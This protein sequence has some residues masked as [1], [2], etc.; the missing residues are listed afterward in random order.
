MGL[1]AGSNRRRLPRRRAAAGLPDVHR[2]PERGRARRRLDGRHRE[3]GLRARA[4]GGRARVHDR[5]WPDR[6]RR[7][8]L[9]PP[10]AG[11]RLHRAGAD[12]QAL[13]RL[14]AA[15]ERG[16][17]G[18]LRADDRGHLDDRQRHRLQQPARRVDDGR[19]SDRRRRRGALL[20]DRRDVV[21]D[22]HRHRAVRDH[23]GR[24]LRAAAAVRDQR[25]R[26]PRRDGGQA[27]RELLR[28]DVDRLE[29][30]LHVLPAVLLRP[31]DRPGHLA[32][33][34]HRPRRE[35]HPPRERSSPARTAWSTASP[36]R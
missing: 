21:A 12:G 11:G 7:P 27:P 29:H 32:A 3:P 9:A 25:G 23:D 2:H 16:D 15:R 20:R 1:P 22:A 30:D 17:H 33:D 6:P 31:H 18:R 4:L 14:G 35:G 34:L 10:R 5:P 8:A 26:R 24:H 13:R 36:A 19:G 28:A